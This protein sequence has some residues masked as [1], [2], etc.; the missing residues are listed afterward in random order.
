MQPEDM[1]FWQAFHDLSPGRTLT[2]FGVGPI[3]LT[4]I[5]A[6]CNLHGLDRQTSLDVMRFTRAMDAVYVEHVNAKTKKPKSTD[7]TTFKDMPKAAKPQG[8]QR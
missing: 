5:E 6:Y 8:K 7:E 1:L 4:E 3:P 2:G